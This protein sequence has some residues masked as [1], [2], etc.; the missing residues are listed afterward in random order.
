VAPEKKEDFTG[1]KLPSGRPLWGQGPRAELKKKSVAWTIEQHPA[2]NARFSCRQP[3]QDKAT[4]HTKK[5]LPLPGVIDWN[6]A[7]A[8]TPV[9]RRCREQGRRPGP[10]TTKKEK[11]KP[12][13]PYEAGPKCG[14]SWKGNAR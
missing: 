8:I 3:Q 11:L 9:R 14:K 6:L 2:Q 7:K 5:N 4:H 10:D 1:Y 13:T 12:E